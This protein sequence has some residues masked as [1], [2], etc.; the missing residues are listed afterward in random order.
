MA[1]YEELQF[2]KSN[3][4]EINREADHKLQ[5]G[6]SIE[7]WLT[8]AIFFL[9]AVA[10]AVVLALPHLPPQTQF[11]IV[12][13]ICLL[14]LAI[15]ALPIAYGSRVRERDALKDGVNAGLMKRTKGTLRSDAN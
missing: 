1:L 3:R 4:V 6:G 13:L 5:A 8:A 10:I 7:G 2:Y 12:V 14:C 15:A 11:S 9:G